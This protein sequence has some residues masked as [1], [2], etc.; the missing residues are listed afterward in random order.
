MEVLQFTEDSDSEFCSILAGRA[1]DGGV[2]GNL[3]F[4]KEQNGKLYIQD[5]AIF[6]QSNECTPN[7]KGQLKPH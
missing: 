1:Q 6:I 4:L 2:R 3:V 5:V 7:L